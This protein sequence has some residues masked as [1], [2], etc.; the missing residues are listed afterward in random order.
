MDPE[1][2]EQDCELTASSGSLAEAEYV[3]TVPLGP[4]ASMLKLAGIVHT[5]GVVSEIGEA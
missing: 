2:G 5:G 3:T 1:T 4:V